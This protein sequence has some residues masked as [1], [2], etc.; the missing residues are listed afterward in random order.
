[1]L[2]LIGWIILWGLTACEGQS[3]ID[4]SSSSLDAV[5]PRGGADVSPDQ[6]RH[7]HH[8]GTIQDHGDRDSSRDIGVQRV[9]EGS[10]GDEAFAHG[11]DFHT[12]TESSLPPGPRDG[13]ETSSGG[14]TAGDD[15]SGRP[16]AGMGVPYDRG[17]MDRFEGG[18]SQSANGGIGTD[19]LCQDETCG[20]RSGG[21]EVMHPSG[22]M[23]STGAIAGHSVV[24][25]YPG[26]QSHVSPSAGGHAHEDG[27]MA[28]T[29]GLLG[30]DLEP[31]GHDD[32]DFVQ[33]GT[34]AHLNTAGLDEPPFA[35]VPGFA[36]AGVEFV[37]APPIM[38]GGGGGYGGG[39]Y[40]AGGY[41]AGGYDAGGSDAGGY[42]AAGSDVVGHDAGGS[43]LAGAIL[44]RGGID[45]TLCA[46][47]DWPCIGQIPRHGVSICD[48]FACGFICGPG[49]E[50]DDEDQP[51][52]CLPDARCEQ[53][54]AIQAQ[55]QQSQS[56]AVALSEGI[57]PMPIPAEVSSASNG[58][59]HLALSSRVVPVVA[60]D[61]GIFVAAS[62]LGA[63]RI[64]AFSGQDFISATDRSTLLGVG[65]VDRLLDNA[66]RW[67]TP[68]GNGESPRILVDGFPAAQMLAARGFQDV[69]V[70]PIIYRQGLWEIRDWRREALEEVDIAIVQV[71]EWGTLHVDPTH[72]DALRSFVHR[73]G[74]L[75]I[76]GSALHWSWWLFDTADRFIGDLIVEGSGISWNV[77][78]VPDL[79]QGVVD[80]GSLAPPIALWCAYL[81]GADLEPAEY[82]RLGDLFTS[83]KAQ[84]R[85]QELD[86]ALTRL[87]RDT[88]RLP[89]AASAPK[90]R[91]SAQVTGQLPPHPWPMPHP[92]TE[93][94]PGLPQ[95]DPVHERTALLD[96]RWTGA[97]PLGF[98]A[99]P[100][101]PVTIS[102]PHEYVTRGW[103]IRVGDL[104]DDLRTISRVRFWH[105]APILWREF[106]L[107]QS[108]I[109][110]VNPFGGPVY[111]VN[112]NSEDM[113]VP[114][115]VS[116]GIPM[117]IYTRG[118]ESDPPWYDDQWRAPT[119]HSVL[120]ERGRVRMVVESDALFAVTDPDGVLEFWTEFHRYHAD[121]AQE[122]QPRMY[123]SHWIFDVQVG[124]GYANAT[125]D[126]IAFPKL[127]EGW[128]LRTQTGDEDWW[129]FGHELGHQFQ[130]SDWRRNGVTEVCVNLFT[131]Y[132]ING[133]IN[134]GDNFQTLSRFEPDAVDHVALQS[135]RWEDAGLLGKL[136]LYRQLIQTFGWDAFKATFASY[137]DSAY[138]RARFG[139]EL[140]GFAIRFSFI[141]ERDLTAFFLHWNY[142]ISDS[143]V[144][145]I[146]GFEFE[147]WRPPG[148]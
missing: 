78:S 84:G 41:D 86:A 51:L 39:G 74:G 52:A 112:E 95:G 31:G 99:P 69:R 79:S 32:L 23:A 123:E 131:M 127:S 1:M 92:W 27:S 72:I 120:Q 8:A 114:V 113:E 108:E 48:G 73:G 122:P 37:D 97:Q 59:L 135:E 58:T 64:V 40:G 143:A 119:P 91:L 16:V 62:Q 136:N 117:T 142:P 128:A 66:V 77:D 121:L 20:L 147:T 85:T 7:V 101:E 12:H 49:F 61:E 89:T 35:G 11:G 87:L 82:A 118:Q 93:T 81:D 106:A 107:D 17:G 71:N 68:T 144:A 141:V 30:G 98:Y 6:G 137:Y 88:P 60:D 103:R 36:A 146:E 26:G 134:G 34:P 13:D 70:T 145:T 22:G 4:A 50:Y 110:V 2:R 18:G 5:R 29:D 96:I 53:V 126:R 43:L 109:Q 104:Y 125:V 111:L 124:W 148:W 38:A 54:D 139:S 133:Y 116:G 105:R 25:E 94:F 15:H 67:V 140:D 138:P 45:G 132:T 9:S 46:P 100:G 14:R 24:D 75:L 19:H 57:D 90:A 83:A 47:D 3:G 42:D 76:A 10:A 115:G 56:W 102:I 65:S 21:E 44:D 28:G 55:A 80:L 129:L 33:G 63:G 130:T